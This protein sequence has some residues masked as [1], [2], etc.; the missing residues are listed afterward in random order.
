MLMCALYERDLRVKKY[1]QHC[2]VLCELY[3]RS[4][5]SFDCH[6]LFCHTWPLVPTGYGPDDSGWLGRN[7]IDIIMEKPLIIIK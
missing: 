5:L 3:G 1:M 7:I 2:V 4:F 6:V